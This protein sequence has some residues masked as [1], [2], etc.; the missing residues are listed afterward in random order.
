[1]AMQGLTGLLGDQLVLRT[2]KAGRTI[3]G[4]RPTYNEN[5]GFSAAQTEHHEAF[6]E[7]SA[8]AK[9]NKD[10]DVYR[11]RAA[12]T[13]QNAYNV[14]MA[15]WFHKPQIKEV[16]LTEWNGQPGQTIRVWA[17]D[18]VK[19]SKVNVV[20]TRPDGTVLEQ[21]EAVQADEMWW[22]YTTTAPA[23]GDARLSVKAHDLPGH[24]AEVTHNGQSPAPAAPPPASAPQ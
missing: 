7:A 10:L 17:T 19:V 3:V 22:D 23:A 18:D 24:A 21:G 9:S 11:Q 1:M 8:Y 12:G 6:R 4:V 15:D 16:D 5:R 2:D 14:A 20:I 13:P